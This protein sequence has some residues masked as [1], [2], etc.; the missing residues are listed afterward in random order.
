MR[1]LRRPRNDLM[2]LHFLV[3][4]RLQASIR[5]LSSSRSRW[6]SLT[7]YEMHALR[8]P[9]ATPNSHDHTREDREDNLDPRGRADIR[10]RRHGEQGP[11][12]R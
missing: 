6:R 4:N 11:A 7:P 9:P 3:P 10:V 5:Q 1:E 2:K 12:N 8:I